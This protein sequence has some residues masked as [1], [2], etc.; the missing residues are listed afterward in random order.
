[1]NK[2]ERH[3]YLVYLIGHLEHSDDN[4]ALDNFFVVAKDI[5]KVRHTLSRVLDY[6]ITLD[7][8]EELITYAEN[9]LGVNRFGSSDDLHYE[10]LFSGRTEGATSAHSAQS[11]D[12]KL[13][14]M[15]AYNDKI[16]T[17]ALVDQALVNMELV[18]RVLEN[19]TP[20]QLT[21]D[22]IKDIAAKGGVVDG[23]KINKQ[24]ADYIAAKIK[25]VQE[26]DGLFG[27]VAKQDI[28][29]GDFVLIDK[30]N[31]QSITPAAE[32]EPSNI[33]LQDLFD[34]FEKNNTQDYAVAMDD[35]GNKRIQKISDEVME[36]FKEAYAALSSEDVEPYNGIYHTGSSHSGVL[37][38]YSDLVAAFS[39]APVEQ[40]QIW[41]FEPF[42]HYFV[43]DIT[44]MRDF[45][46]VYL[47]EDVYHP[48]FV[49]HTPVVGPFKDLEE[50]DNYFDLM[51]REEAG[52]DDSD[53]V[54]RVRSLVSMIKHYEIKDD[55]ANYATIIDKLWEQ[56]KSFLLGNI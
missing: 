20:D 7:Q 19:Y 40:K 42:Q 35:N 36:E 51:V 30:D 34:E 41:Y 3:D 2:Q 5:L 23:I 33:T 52:M 24:T 8:Y 1:M 16:I 11:I 25:E 10:H 56:L 26:D 4:T 39:N 55:A 38:G 21:I 6:P 27:F 22:M 15:M 49:K 48:D 45:P 54:N 31:N 28:K 14:N 29:K 18:D 37:I 50:L 46:Y 47:R 53:F 12:E 43:G 32:M 9:I 44:G 17:D 13:N